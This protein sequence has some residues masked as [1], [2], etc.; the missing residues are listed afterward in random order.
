[1]IEIYKRPHER[2]YGYY[3]LPLLLGDRIIARCDLK[4][5]RDA[6]RLRLRALHP[7]PKVRWTAG[8]EAAL[9]R[10]LA[11]LAALI[12]VSSILREA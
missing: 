6:D 3:V 12:G 4:T 5:E 11:R 7:E 9:E 8:K 2:V 10:A 1:V